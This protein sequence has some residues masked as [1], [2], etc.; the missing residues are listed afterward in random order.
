MNQAEKYKVLK[1]SQEF[2]FDDGLG[3]MSMLLLNISETASEIFGILKLQDI[4]ENEIKNL[5]KKINDSDRS[6][7]RIK[8]D[9]HNAGNSSVNI[10]ERNLNNIKLFLKVNLQIEITVY[11]GKKIDD[12]VK[13]V[14]VKHVDNRQPA[15]GGVEDGTIIDT[16]EPTVVYKGKILAVAK[17]IVFRKQDSI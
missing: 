17:V 4:S 10:L 16:I 13:E 11:T 12:W 2:S 14:E 9:P 15:S 8:T 5:A 7:Q 6:I 1:D 3:K